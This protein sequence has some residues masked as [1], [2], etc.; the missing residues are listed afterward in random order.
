MIRRWFRQAGTMAVVTWA[1]QHKG[2]VVRAA[3]L[4]K[5]APTLVRDGRTA[6]LAAEAKAVIALDGVLPS[7]T[8]IRITGIEDGSVMLRGQPAGQPLEAARHALTTIGTITDV[9]TDDADQP[10][11]DSMLAGARP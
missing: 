6:D 10:T 3:D 1:W 8:D 9:R 7:D 11:L 5:R 2:S 4:A